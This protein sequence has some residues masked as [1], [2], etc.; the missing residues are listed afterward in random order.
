MNEKKN[1][2]EEKN[3]EKFPCI[4]IESEGNEDGKW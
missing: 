1:Q 2:R 3:V 4:L